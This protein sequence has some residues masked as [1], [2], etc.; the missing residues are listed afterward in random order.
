MTR[1][2]ARVPPPD[3]PP[4]D[5]G[6]TSDAA[7]PQPGRADVLLPGTRIE[8]FEIERVIA[9][10]GFGV[11]YLAHDQ[12][13]QR[14]VAIKEYFPDTLAVRAENRTDVMLRA[15]AHAEAFERGRR[16]F[17]EESQ[18]LAGCRHPS[19]VEVLRGWEGHGTV[20]RVM[21]YYAGQ[22]LLSLR[23]AIDVPPDEPSL[24]ALLEGLLGA[25]ERLHDAGVVHREISPAN[26]LLLPD[27]RPVLMDFAAPRRAI[28]GD[29]ARALMTLLAPSFAPTEQTAPSPERPLG[30]WTDMF[31]LG[32]LVRWCITGQLPPPAS[33]FAQ[34]PAEPMA[35]LVRRMNKRYPRLHYSTS[36][37]SAI[38][39]ALVPLPDDRTRN[40]ADFRRRLDDH[41][42]VTAQAFDLDAEPR[43]PAGL[44]P[45]AAPRPA[46]FDPSLPDEASARPPAP[47]AKPSALP[48]G[49]EPT[50]GPAG[51]PEPTLPEFEPSARAGGPAVDI[52]LFGPVPDDSPP[53]PVF[54]FAGRS[55]RRQQRTTAAGVA[56]LVAAIAAGAWWFDQQREN[57]Q[58]QADL[59]RVARQGRLTAAPPAS[60]AAGE[61]A[62]AIDQRSVRQTTAPT[63][64]TA[65][66]AGGAPPVPQQATAAV[67]PPASPSASAPSW[68]LPDTPTAAIR[69]SDNSAPATAT[70]TPS[71]ATGAPATTNGAP[72]VATGAPTTVTGA[73]ATGAAT[74]TAPTAP[75][76][77]TSGTRAP[78][79][80][81][82]APETPLP[83]R[84]ADDSATQATAPSTRAAGRPSS[85]T[86]APP[87]ALVQHGLPAGKAP[88]PA[89][90]QRGDAA[91]AA[92]AGPREACGNRTQFS[93]YRCMQTQCAQGRWAEH[94][95]CKRLRARD[96]V[97]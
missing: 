44:P 65:A 63:A 34:P 18:V 11:V 21:P 40:V 14:Q 89:E 76:L 27:D 90:T 9:A 25:L 8:E 6:P 84:T 26:I 10:S 66:S 72:A 96:E 85:P 23:Q 50:W 86:G 12:S 3:P 57:G 87:T 13:L 69:S 37:L 67:S 48:R 54:D 77:S 41:P 92:G 30:P 46:A 28:V 82:G 49:A 91:L 2:R 7:D 68:S 53:P 88:A 32:A 94:P 17:V 20:Y 74:A 45:A 29:Q 24:R 33:L 80:G 56:A 81:A 16:A 42:A 71:T 61:D 73:P 60:A 47:A 59:A 22:S 64:D 36:F 19:L 51:G 5:G 79:D 43:E 83:S 4:G 97:E 58:A 15:A 39:A 78:A 95:L 75:A 1:H 62:S 38:D 55:R 31:A 70:G 35:A 93:L 52:P